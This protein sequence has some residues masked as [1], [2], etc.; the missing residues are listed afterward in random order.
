MDGR[1]PHF[2]GNLVDRNNNGTIEP[3]EMDINTLSHPGICGFGRGTFDR[4]DTSHSGHITIPDYW[5]LYEVLPP[6]LVYSE[7]MSLRLG[8][9]SIELV[10]PGLNH[11]DDGTV[12]L[13]PAERVAFSADFPA[14]ALVVDS[15]RSMPSA[16]G[17]FDHHPIAEWLKSYETL[18]ALDFDILVQGHGQVTFTKSDAAEGRQFLEDLRDAVSNGMAQGKSL[19]QLKDTLMVEKYRGWAYYDMLRKDDIEAAYLNL[20]NY[21]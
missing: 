8:G 18:E 6:D 11:A 13:L 2:P 15:M 14:D 5:R 9:R 7:R 3:E 16:C 20:K 21:P 1:F 19:A 17:A 12:V 10:F 4:L